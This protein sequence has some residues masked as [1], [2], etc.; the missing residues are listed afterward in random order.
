VRDDEGIYVTFTDGGTAQW[1]ERMLGGGAAMLGF[2]AVTLSVHP[3][4]TAAA[5]AGPV[6]W[7]D[8]TLVEKG[9]AA[10]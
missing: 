6:V 3:A 5:A 7:D 8:K 1:A 2:H 4:P 9:C 10:R